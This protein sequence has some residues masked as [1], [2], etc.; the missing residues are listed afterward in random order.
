MKQ[1]DLYVREYE[2]YKDKE[3]IFYKYK[4]CREK[5][6]WQSIIYNKLLKG[7][8]LEGKVIATQKE[9]VKL[10][11]NIDENQDKGTAYWFDYA[12]PSVNIMYS[13]PLVEESARLYFPNE[14]TENPIV[15]GCIRKNGDTCTQTAEPANRYF[16]TESGNEIAMLPDTLSIKSGS[17]RNISI[18][19]DDK[20]GIHLKSPKKLKLNADGEIT[21]KT[22]KRV[23]IKAKT[24]YY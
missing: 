2:A 3:E 20:K 12:P 10:H 21:I 13:M 22:Q 24:R 15:T 4:L 19:F 1:E 18:S 16:Q 9:Q 8:T 23:K 11:L 17:R 6:V 7:A 5:G 14:E